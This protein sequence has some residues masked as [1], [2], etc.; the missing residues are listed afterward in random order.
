MSILWRIDNTT[1]L[2]HI[3][4]EGSL[5]GRALLEGAKRILLLAHQRQL[6]LL[7]APLGRE[8]PGRRSLEVPVDPGLA[9]RPQGFSPD[10]GSQG[11]PRDRS[12]CFSPIC[13]DEG[14]LLLERRGHPGSDRRTQPE[15][16][17]QTG[18]PLSSR[19]PPQEGCQEAGTVQGDVQ[20]WFASLKALNVKDVRCLPFSEDLISHH[21]PD[22]RGASSKPGETFSCRLDDFRGY[23]GVY[24]VSDRSF[25]LITAGWK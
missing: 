16:G 21:R 3:R 11:S 12:L 18:F 25:R 4:K 13:P 7:P 9:P 6:R 5:W 10:I 24:A 20:T 22:N 1:A 23:W 15:V 19:S 8:R 17:L 14:L 2:A